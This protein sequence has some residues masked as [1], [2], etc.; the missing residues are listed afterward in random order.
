MWCPFESWSI[1]LSM[2]DINNNLQT[3]IGNNMLYSG[4]MADVNIDI[5]C[6][7]RFTQIFIATTFALN[8][9]NQTILPYVE[10]KRLYLNKVHGLD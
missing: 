1:D 5:K 8:T 6:R 4:F 3:H 10:Y 9:S 7:K 2:S